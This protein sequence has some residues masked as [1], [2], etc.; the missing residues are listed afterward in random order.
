MRIL[1][2]LSKLTNEFLRN[3]WLIANQFGGV[4]LLETSLQK[5]R[6]G[7]EKEG[8]VGVTWDNV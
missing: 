2:V 8:Y 1:K 6:E 7:M 5:H 3:S 4:L